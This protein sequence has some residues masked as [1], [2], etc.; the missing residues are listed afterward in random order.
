M[1]SNANSPPP[2]A[3]IVTQSPVP[4]PHTSIVSLIQKKMS[5][6][7]P[8]YES[9]AVVKLG[10][11]ASYKAALTMGLVRGSGKVKALCNRIAKLTKGKKTE[12]C[13]GVDADLSPVG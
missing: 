13:R 1:L 6:Q 10:A 5:T 8:V 3:S 4:Q 7:E 2:I 12:I 9:S 11:G